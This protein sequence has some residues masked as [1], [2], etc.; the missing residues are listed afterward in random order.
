MKWFE[1]VTGCDGCYTP[2][3]FKTE[4]EAESFVNMIEETSEHLDVSEG[5][6]LVDTN[7]INFW[8][9]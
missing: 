3:R 5:P 4:E 1:V 9:E 8:G 6:Y 2:K 7:D